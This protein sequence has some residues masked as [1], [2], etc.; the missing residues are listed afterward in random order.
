MLPFLRLLR[1]LQTMGRGREDF[2]TEA[3]VST[4][5]SQWCSEY[6]GRF[7][8][9]EGAYE[10]AGFSEGSSFINE[11]GGNLRGTAR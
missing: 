8:N 7:T 10:K 9:Y 1:Y 3:A 6:D 5:A 4:V 11:I 2:Q